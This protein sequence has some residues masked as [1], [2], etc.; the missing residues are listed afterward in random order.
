MANRKGNIKD[1]S[2][3]GRRVVKNFSVGGNGFAGEDEEVLAGL[4]FRPGDDFFGGAGEESGRG[5]GEGEEFFEG[6][7]ELFSRALFDPLAGKDEG[8]DGTG[9]VEKE[10]RWG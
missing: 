10:G 6:G 5:R 7:L 3:V 4:D 2:G 8:G 1:L 9:G